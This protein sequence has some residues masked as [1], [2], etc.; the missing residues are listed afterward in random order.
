MAKANVSVVALMLIQTE[1]AMA[2]GVMH[3]NLLRD[4]ESSLKVLDIWLEGCKLE[5]KILKEHGKACEQYIADI[6][7]PRSVIDMTNELLDRV[8]RKEVAIDSNL[9]LRDLP[10]IAE[11]VGAH[12]QEFYRL[13][14]K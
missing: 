12:I 9:V 7:S 5:L 8:N 10:V 13:T 3:E 6:S 1:L 14:G 4:I 2:G 11:R